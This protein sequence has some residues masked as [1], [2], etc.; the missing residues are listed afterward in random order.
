MLTVKQLKVICKS[1]GI[2]GYSHLK[3]ADLVKLC[4]NPS[5]IKLVFA[6]V[7]E[8]NG[9]RKPLI[10]LAVLAALSIPPYAPPV[11]LVIA[12][13]YE[14]SQ[15]FLKKLIA[16]KHVGKRLKIITIEAAFLFDPS[17]YSDAII[18][19]ANA[20]WTGC[21]TNDGISL[22]FGDGNCYNR[23]KPSLLQYMR[24]DNN[25][26]KYFGAYMLPLG[27]QWSIDKKSLSNTIQFIEQ[28]HQS[29]KRVMLFAGS[30]TAPVPLLDIYAWIE[31]HPSHGWSFVLMGGIT[32][33]HPLSKVVRYGGKLQTVLD[34]SAG[35]L[36]ES[37]GVYVVQGYLEFE[38]V[39]PLVDFVVTNCGAG[40]VTVPLIAGVPQSCMNM[41]YMGSDKK[42][43]QDNISELELGKYNV[44]TMNEL[45][46]GM[47]Q[48]LPKYQ[49]RAT[50][51]ALIYNKEQRVAY[52][53]M[54]QLFND[55]FTHKQLVLNMKETGEIPMDYT[56]DGKNMPEEI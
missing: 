31:E 3:K 21:N 53:R 54:A 52:D 12:K 10:V 48:L 38:D 25:T 50:D 4:N 18:F 24:H 45:M 22:D 14:K 47:S 1:H 8:T 6:A 9:D 30:I 20:S 28:A 23:F 44:S 35:P 11:I 33:W 42:Q 37:H 15:S 16:E 39:I 36:P 13:E 29:N 46:S 32:M 5:H 51:A 49:K 56:I 26:K 41:N 34:N 19:N 40:S 2:N 7:G 17:T 43:N 27:Q 55:I